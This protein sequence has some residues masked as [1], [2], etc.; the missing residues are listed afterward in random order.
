LPYLSHSSKENGIT[1]EKGGR[2]SF[3]PNHLPTADGNLT[4]LTKKTRIIQISKRI[5]PV[6]RM[7]FANTDDSHLAHAVNSQK[8]RAVLKPAFISISKIKRLSPT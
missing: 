6:H 4:D 1:V 3:I 5:K 7:P 2:R 8:S